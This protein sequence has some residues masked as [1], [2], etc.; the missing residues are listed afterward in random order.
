MKLCHFPL[1]KALRSCL[2]NP[3]DNQNKFLYILSNQEKNINARLTKLDIISTFKPRQTKLQNY[4]KMTIRDEFFCCYSAITSFFSE[5]AKLESKYPFCDTTDMS[6]I[7]FKFF[8][9]MPFI[10]FLLSNLKLSF[11]YLTSRKID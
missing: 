4:S 11:S 10:L 8:L 2:S 5:M 3:N 6:N 7:H 9:Y 1:G